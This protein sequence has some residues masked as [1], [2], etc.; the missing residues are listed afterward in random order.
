MGAI[1]KYP[2][3]GWGGGS[4]VSI[5]MMGIFLVSFLFIYLLVCS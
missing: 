4:V 3:G 1:L 5:C 2:S